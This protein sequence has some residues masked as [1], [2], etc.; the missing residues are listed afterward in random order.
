VQINASAVLM[1]RLFLCSCRKRILH[2]C[3]ENNVL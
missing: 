1:L 3:R 2:K